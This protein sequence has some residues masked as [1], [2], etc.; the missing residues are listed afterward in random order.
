M[1]AP[2]VVAAVVV[3]IIQLGAQGPPQF[4]RVNINLG[5][6]PRGIVVADFNG[7]GHLDFATANYQSPNQISVYLG[8]G[9]RGFHLNSQIHDVDGLFGIASADF[10]HDGRSDLA[11]TFG[12]RNVVA[13]YIWTSAG[14]VGTGGFQSPGGDA[15]EIVAADFNRDGNPDIAY[16]S[17]AC[18]CVEVMLGVGNGNGDMTFK[19]DFP[20]GAGAHGVAA[21]DLD[22]DGILDLVVTNALAGTATVMKGNGDGTFTKGVSM[23]TGSSPRNVTVGDFDHDGWLDFAVANTGTNNI[24]VFFGPFMTN[25]PRGFTQGTISSPRDIENADVNGDGNL[26]LIVSSYT[27]GKVFVL[28]GDGAGGFTTSVVQ[29]SSGS[30]ARDIAVGDMDEDGRTDVLVANQTAGTASIFFNA[31]PF[32]GRPGS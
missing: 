15:R 14:F 16:G 12:D 13:F 8:D 18:G 10:N 23:K 19:G 31:T 2:V 6:S 32:R 22:R 20:A 28:G 17:Y 29:L 26:D 1:K 9:A 4:S 25:T 27:T 5:G 3:G 11:V 7:D 21:A 24:A 30:G